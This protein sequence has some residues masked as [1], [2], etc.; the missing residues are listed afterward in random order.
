PVIEDDRALSLNEPALSEPTL[1]CLRH[2]KDR[3]PVRAVLWL[4]AQQQP[5][6]QLD[7][8]VLVEEAVVDQ[9][10]VL[11]AGPPTQTR[12]LRLLHGSDS[13]RCYRRLPRGVNVC[14]GIPLYAPVPSG[15]HGEVA[16]PGESSPIRRRAASGLTTWATRKCATTRS[17]DH[18]TR[19][20]PPPIGSRC[21]R[22]SGPV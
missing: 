21:R 2:E 17:I 12:P 6:E 1:Q 16:P 7:R 14:G 18:G 5:V 19:A 4:L 10:R 20:A 13:P 3:R 8:V 9:S 15:A 11:V 22:G